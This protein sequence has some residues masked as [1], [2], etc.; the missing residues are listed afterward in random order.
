MPRACRALTLKAQLSLAEC[1]GSCAA[2]LCGSQWLE[3]CSALASFFADEGR[4]SQAA[5]CLR[6][7]DAMAAKMAAEGAPVDG[8]VLVRGVSRSLRQ[9]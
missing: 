1:E 4:F 6:A 5:R 3:H 9:R 2:E 7:C 8:E